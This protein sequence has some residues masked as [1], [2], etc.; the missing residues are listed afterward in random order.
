M[1]LLDLFN[2]EGSEVIAKVFGFFSSKNLHFY[3]I[4]VLYYDLRDL[5]IYRFCI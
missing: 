3:V 5:Q 4:A 2:L 1:K